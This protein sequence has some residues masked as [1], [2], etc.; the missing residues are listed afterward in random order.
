MA[1]EKATRL[2]GA[3]TTVEKLKGRLDERLL[4]RR[5][6]DSRQRL[7][8]AGNGCSLRSDDLDDRTSISQ[9]RKDVATASRSSRGD[10]AAQGSAAKVKNASI[11]VWNLRR[12][13]L[14]CGWT[15][16]RARVESTSMEGTS[17]RRQGS[18]S[19]RRRMGEDVGEGGRRWDGGVAGG[20]ALGTEEVMRRRDRW[21]AE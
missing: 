17:G 9:S 13:S 15:T 19:R 7:S 10:E 16:A 2:R 20:G 3:S 11:E 14:A 1:N 5:R 6:L 21:G 4:M 18:G 8:R 12:A